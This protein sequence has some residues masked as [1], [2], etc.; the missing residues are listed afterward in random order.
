[1]VPLLCV[2]VAVFMRVSSKYVAH[3]Y[4]ARAHTHANIHGTPTGRFKVGSRDSSGPDIIL[5]RGIR[6]YRYV[7]NCMVGSRE[8]G[9]VVNARVRGEGVRGSECVVKK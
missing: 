3:S 4:K 8:Y 5:V 7:I 2:K 9:C 6:A 1:M